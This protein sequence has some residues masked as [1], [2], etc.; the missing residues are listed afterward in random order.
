M[1]RRLAFLTPTELGILDYDEPELASGQVR[2]RTEIAS[3]KHGT[4]LGMSEGSTLRDAHFD[5]QWHLFRE[6]EPTPSAAP[7]QPR[8]M[9]GCTGVGVVTDLA[10]GVTRWKPG[11]RVFGYLDVRETNVRDEGKLWELGTI[12]PEV[13][14]CLDPAYVAFHSVREAGVRFGDSVAVVGLGAIG[15]LAVRMARL[16]G[17]EAVFAVDPLAIRREVALGLG[18]DEALDP[19]ACD[20]GLVIHEHTG[21]QGVDVAIEAAG[22]YHA[23]DAAIRSTRVGGTVCMTGFY[24][25]PARTVWFG[26]EAHHNRLSF[27]VPH[28][29]GWANLPRDYPRWDENRAHEAMVSLMRKGILTAPGVIQPILTLDEAPEAWNWVRR[30]PERVV[31]FAVRF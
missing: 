16:S 30:E 19:T 3:A 1:P 23:L 20:A 10:D 12:D 22:S 17:A 24:Q 2:I 15:L 28:G 14:L 13:A 31:K 29:C 26:R 27:V 21:T 4:N 8:G 6:N 7:P 18:A 25:G 9:A 5:P 11:D